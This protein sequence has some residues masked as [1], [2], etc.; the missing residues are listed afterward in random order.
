MP[1]FSSS[2]FSGFG[3]N[4]GGFYTVYRDVFEAV[5]KE[6]AMGASTDDDDLDDEDGSS[7]RS[8][9]G[10]TPSDLPPAPSFG[11]S[12]SPE[13]DVRQFYA[14]W[15]NFVSRQSFAQAD[16]Y[17]LS[18]A[19]NRQIRRLMEKENKKLREVLRREFVETVRV[20]TPAPHACVYPGPC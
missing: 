17:R 5:A 4:A 11:T 2:A 8:S 3:D 9:R 14:Y 20:R 19:P 10:S 1:F 15:S 12:Q 13:A 6:E 18:E 7:R 16:K